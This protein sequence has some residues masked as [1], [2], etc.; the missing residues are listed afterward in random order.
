MGKMDQVLGEIRQKIS[1]EYIPDRPNVENV[2]FDVMR[3][4]LMEALGKFNG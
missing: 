2:R 4:R 3:D 1:S